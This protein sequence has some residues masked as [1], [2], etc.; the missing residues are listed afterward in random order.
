MEDKSECPN[1]E[2][3][4]EEAYV[5]D[6]DE[7]GRLFRPMLQCSICSYRRHINWRED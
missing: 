5:S 4:M 1:C 7:R 2:I 6:W 3:E